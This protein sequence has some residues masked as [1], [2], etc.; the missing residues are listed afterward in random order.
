MLTALPGLI[1]GTRRRLIRFLGQRN[2]GRI[3]SG[4]NAQVMQPPHPQAGFKPRRPEACDSRSRTASG[5]TQPAQH[6][7]QE[8]GEGNQS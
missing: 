3:S 4:R 6:Q 8:Q 1:F 7:G 5:M 2:S